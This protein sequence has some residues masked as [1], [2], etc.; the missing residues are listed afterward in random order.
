MAVTATPQMGDTRLE[1]MAA[2][3][4]F[5]LPRNY[6]YA[7]A[8]L[9]VVPQGGVIS[10]TGNGY[11]SLRIPSF[12]RLLPAISTRSEISDIAP[13]QLADS[14]VTINPSLYGNAVQL[15]YKVQHESA[16]D[17]FQI[18][19]KLVAENASESVDY[20]ARSVAIAGAAFEYGNGTA[21]TAVS[22]AGKI[23]PGILF[24]AAGFLASAPKLDGGMN[25]PTIGGGI[26]AIMRNA[27]IADLSENS[28]IILLGQYRDAAPETV[29][30]GEVGSH[31]SGIRLIV[32]DN[33]KIFQG[34]GTTVVG[35]PSSGSLK[36]AAEQGAT[37]IFV[38]SSVSS[39]GTLSYMTLGTPE[40]S[41]NGE[42]TNVEAIYVDAGSTNIQVR[43]GAPNGGLI[44]AY[45]SGA[46]LTANSQVHAVVFMGADALIKVHDTDSG[47]NPK[48]LL[49]QNDGLLEQ[50]DALS[51]RWFGGF[52]RKAENRLYRAEVGSER[53]VLGM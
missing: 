40:T 51:W 38:E 1:V 14:A 36:L 27:L 37:T 25:Q 6:I 22:T 41:A 43:G 8:P 31:V 48:L 7:Q 10:G 21:R 23:T 44:Y 18:A 26:A 46:A 33:A 49:P 47:P 11:S 30:M 53:Q 39:A 20:I 42:Q 34:G 12:H 5:I 32:S 4:D 9:A 24:N 28:S 29:L 15:S 2:E 45:S 35:L 17:L 50:F 19:G 16:I 3:F 13:V 52:G